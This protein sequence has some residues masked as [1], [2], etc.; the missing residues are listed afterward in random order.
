[1]ELKAYKTIYRHNKN[2]KIKYWAWGFLIAG[3]IFL[4][5]PWTQNVRAK[6]SVTT[7]RQEQRP[8]ELNSII[9]GKIIKWYI[10]E[11]DFV[12]AGD[13]ILQIGEV[14]DDYFDPNLIGRTGQQLDAK[15]LSVDYYKN[16]V[17]ATQNQIGAI[18]NTRALKQSQLQN[19][20][21]QLQIKLQSDSAELAAAANDYSIAAKQYKR[22]QAMYDSGLVSLT[23]LEQRNASFQNA[24]A[25]KI[26][27]ENK[28]VN[29]RQE[30]NIANIE[31]SAVNQDYL[32]KLSK[33]QGDQF[34]SMSQIAGGQGEVAKLQNQVSNYNIRSGM[35]FITSPQSGQVTKAK[36]AG[37]GEIIKEGEML[38]EIVPDKPDY[39]VELYIEPVDLPLIAK[40]QS[41]QF[42]FDG[43]PAIVFSGWPNTSYGTFTGEVSAVENAVSVNGK[44]RVL[45]T[46]DVSSTKRWPQQL[47][48]GTGAQGFA[49]LKNV[50]VWYELWRNINGFPPDYYKKNTET[51]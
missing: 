51:K 1:M 48:V 10:K 33:A 23:Q 9:P 16:K 29:T 7:L 41:V 49:L 13:T 26:G 34:Q 40:G 43:F 44:F 4:F 5:L 3:G 46:E 38:V 20:I 17:A 11:G 18:E 31:I 25:K 35:Y 15:Q 30:L 45:V 32:E 36:K 27:A 37:I 47:K 42:L 19:K 24:A 8:Q 2:S 22:Q 6:G 28:L 21:Q 12:N 39:A 14:K 50:P